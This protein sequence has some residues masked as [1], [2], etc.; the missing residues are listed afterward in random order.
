MKE[1]QLISSYQAI[2]LITVF[3]IVIA[4]SY[5]PAVNTPPGN[6]DIWISIILSIPWTIAISFPILYLSNK[7][8]NLTLIEY[9]EKILGKA[10]GKIVGIAYAVFLLFYVI[11]FVAILS[12]VLTS[13]IFPQT[14]SW[15]L[16]LILLITS[17]YISFKGLEGL[18]RGAEIFVPIIFLVILTFLI[19][20]F[21]LFD[22]NELLPI[23]KDSTFSQINIGAR[24]IAFKFTDIIILAMFVPNLENR[25]ELN[26]IFIRS[27]LISMLVLIIVVLCTQLSLGIEQTKHA[28]FPFFTFSRLINLFDFIQRIES[29]YVM[30]WTVAN[31]W[32]VSGYLY[33]L[34][35]NL[36]QTLNSKSNEVYIIPMSILIFI[37]STIL[38]NNYSVVGVSQPL[39]FLLYFS[40]IAFMFAVPCI[41]LIV[42]F[43]RRKK[44]RE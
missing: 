26:K 30:A 1:E 8:S 41:T 18:G 4:F 44:L 31:V 14:P 42:Y 29:I 24:D 10:I 25:K 17:S 12:E 22:F 37:L 9:T 43:F 33:S 28:D 5:L 23:L 13:T 16:I 7:F 3:R 34:T 6:Q 27:L 40:S 35:I 39:Q 11:T 38:K 19:F 20:G 21:N 15:I 2:L 32:K 36:K